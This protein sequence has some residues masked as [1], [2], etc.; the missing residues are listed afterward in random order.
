MS[1]T[2]LAETAVFRDFDISN[3]VNAGIFCLHSPGITSPVSRFSSFTNPLGKYNPLDFVNKKLCRTAIA[4]TNLVTFSG[5][6]LIGEFTIQNRAAI[7][8]NAFS[9]QRRN[10]DNL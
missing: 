4:G 2:V 9:L 3:G 8:P 10:L 6:K 5:A 7:I 1:L